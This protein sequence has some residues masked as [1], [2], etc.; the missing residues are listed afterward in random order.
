MIFSL[1]SLVLLFACASFVSFVILGIYLILNVLLAA[2]YS[3]WK[4]MHKEQLLTL[5]V[6]RYHNLLVAWQVLDAMLLGPGVS[7]SAACFF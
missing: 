2:T 3:G 6:H 5:R 7:R 4:Q 1:F